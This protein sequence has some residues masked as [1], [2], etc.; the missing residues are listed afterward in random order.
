[1]RYQ[2]RSA[3]NSNVFGVGRRGSLRFLVVVVSGVNSIALNALIL[4]TTTILGST[5]SHLNVY[6]QFAG[7]DWGRIG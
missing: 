4:A 3:G 7:V 1:M 5:A 2:T 6:F